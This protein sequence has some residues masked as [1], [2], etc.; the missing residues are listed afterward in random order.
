MQARELLEFKSFVSSRLFGGLPGVVQELAG[1]EFDELKVY[2]PGDSPLDINHLASLQHGRLFVTIRLPDRELEIVFVFDTSRSL[3]MSRTKVQ[4]LRELFLVGCEIALEYQALIT[5]AK[6][7]N[8]QFAEQPFRQGS[9]RSMEIEI[10]NFVD[11]CIV[12]GS[13]RDF[14]LAKAFNKLAQRGKSRTLFAVV[15]S[16]FLYPPDYGD[17]LGKFLAGGHHAVGAAIL[18]PVEKEIPKSLCGAL[19]VRDSETGVSAF[20]ARPPVHYLDQHKALW[21]KHRATLEV[22]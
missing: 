19:R 10:D 14:D 18:D 20:I 21:S 13:E 22:V 7:E 1:V 2:E 8:S 11:L 15:V 9:R 4:T 17:A 16:D 5:V 6:Q 3:A 12:G